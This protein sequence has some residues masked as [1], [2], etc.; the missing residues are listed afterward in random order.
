MAQDT[1]QSGGLADILSVQL[2]SFR[3]LG[4]L[5]AQLDAAQAGGY[6]LV[7]TIGSHLADPA[8][9]KAGLD[10]RGLKAPTGHVGLPDL[11]SDLS[12]VADAAQAAGI[13]QLFMPAL[14]PDERGGTA[15]DWRR[16]GEELGRMAEAMA[17]RSIA[18][19]YHNHNW[20]LARLE[21][22]RTGLENLFEGA[23]GSPLVWQA[24]IAWLARG[25]V[26]AIEWLDRYRGLLASAHVKDQAPAGQNE[27][28]D[29]WA[30]LGAG[31]LDWPALWAAAR[32]DGAGIMVVEHDKPADPAG[33]ALRSHQYLSAHVSGTP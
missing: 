16:A 22:G 33:F 3:T 31:T 4:G 32:R 17:G 21:D 9:L 8:A 30:D 28:E 15:A 6:R 1:R 25:G 2:Y 29:G 5:D 19:G 13:G 24:D 11:R 27:D 23:A 14:P 10:A 18:F 7:E 20:E 12:R 26:E